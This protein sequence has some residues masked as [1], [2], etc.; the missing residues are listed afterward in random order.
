MRSARSVTTFAAGAASI[1]ALTAASF[2]PHALAQDQAGAPPQVEAPAAAPQAA[3]PAPLSESVAAVVNDDIISSYDLMQRMRLLMATSGMQPTQENLPQ[4]QQ[5]AL[6]SL[7]DE[8]LQMQELRRVEKQQKITIISTDKEVD[9]QVADIAQSNKMTSDQLKQSLVQQGIG[10]DTWRAQLRADSSW[11]S[12][13]QGRYGSR[14]RIGEDQIKAYQ[15]RLAESAAKPQYQ[16]SEVFLDASR[17]GGM[18]V[19]VNGAAQLI[20]QMQQGAPFAA[21]ARQFSG[22]ATAA[23]GGDVGWVNQGEMPTEVD[24]ALEQLRPGQLSRPIQVKDGV[25]IIYLRDKRAGSKTAIVDLKQVAAP[26]P[27]DATEAQVA[28][29]TKL[30]TDL[31]PKINSCQTLETVAGKV[32]GL[33]AGD[34]GEAEITDLAPAFQEAASKLDIGQ[35]SDPIR[36]DA[37]LHLIAVCGKRQGGAN[38]PTH[39]QIENRL[40]GQQLALISK[41]YLRDLRNQATIETR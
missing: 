28:A 14:L 36:T 22:S 27:A 26:L 29:A 3:A 13:I 41:R 17:V 15:R 34:L 32:D 39:D 11:Q 18:E 4:I 30:L 37:G 31:R 38:A 25:Y 33:V 12:W 23:N 2:A 20:A 19:A 9:E 1:L 7:I 6:R 35:I 21:V 8:R 40:R 5:E 24:E 10:L 16:I